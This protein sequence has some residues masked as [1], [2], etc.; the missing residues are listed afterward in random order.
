MLARRA[1][2][3]DEAYFAGEA[4][5]SLAKQRERERSD[6]LSFDK[7]PGDYFGAARPRPEDAARMTKTAP[8]SG[9]FHME[10]QRW[11]PRA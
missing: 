1:A 2:Y 5:D 8:R 11:P 9:F 10:N 7:L 4:R 3:W 6:S